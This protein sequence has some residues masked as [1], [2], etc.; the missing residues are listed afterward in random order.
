M[1][2]DI[3]SMQ[4][5]IPLNKSHLS[6]AETHWQDKAVLFWRLT[7]S[8]IINALVM[9]ALTV[10][11]I[12]VVELIV[13]RNEDQSIAILIGMGVVSSII[14]VSFL[15]ISQVWGTSYKV[16]AVYAPALISAVMKAQTN[17]E[18]S[19]QDAIQLLTYNN[20][21]LPLGDFMEMIRNNELGNV[22][23]VQKFGTI[24]KEF[25]NKV[26]TIEL[27]WGQHSGF[28]L[29]EDAKAFKANPLLASS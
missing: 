24:H 21:L 28:F 20:E 7:R 22:P 8:R 27:Y 14:T 1:A 6:N 2:S 19:Q 23:N 5:K 9:I 15:R 10:F 12:L 25:G 26:Y 4:I 18:L 11:S 13:G 17:Y 3:F 29:L 16:G